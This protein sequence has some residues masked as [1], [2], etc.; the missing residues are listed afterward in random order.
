MQIGAGA[1]QVV[2]GQG[3]RA[4][5][6]WVGIRDLGHRQTYAAGG[7]VELSEERRSQR[8]RV[9]RRADVVAHVGGVGIG[10]GAG[11]P[12]QGGLGFKYL[13]LQP[14]AGAYDGRGKPV[15]AAAHHGDVH[16]MIRRHTPAITL[17]G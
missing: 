14:G 6:Q 9:D 15:G 3:G 11:A 8:Q 7:E 10:Q 16:L 2:V 1:V 5:G 12:A 4:A 13:N 17:S